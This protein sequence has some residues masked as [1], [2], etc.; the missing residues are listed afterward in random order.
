ML[1]AADRSTQ[2]L[3]AG[4]LTFHG[5]RQ[6]S[7]F[8]PISTIVVKFVNEARG[9]SL[10]IEKT[11]WINPCRYYHS[12]PRGWTVAEAFRIPI[13]STGYPDE[14][15]GWF[16]IWAS[17]DKYSEGALSIISSMESRR[18][19]SHPRPLV[20]DNGQ[21]YCPFVRPSDVRCPRQTWNQMERRGSLL[22]LAS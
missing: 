5:F 4:D 6:K 7:H 19:D 22:W 18:S 9:Y 2:C 10:Y 21:W 17:Q 14:L 20:L 11:T 8:R 16:T 3:P 13:G 15:F 12:W 1:I